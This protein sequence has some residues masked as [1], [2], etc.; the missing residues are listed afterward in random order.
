MVKDDVHRHRKPF[1]RMNP[2]LTILNDWKTQSSTVVMCLVLAAG[3]GN[4]GGDG[5][6]QGCLP[7][8]PAA[9]FAD[10]GLLFAT[11]SRDFQASSLHFMSFERGG[12]SC[13]ILSGESGDP[14]VVD[15]GRTEFFNRQIGRLNHKTIVRQQDKLLVGVEQATPSAGLGD[16]QDASYLD[17]SEL[18]LQGAN[19]SFLVDGV[20][21][22]VSKLDLGGSK[23]RPVKLIRYESKFL[24]LH[25]GL[26]ADFKPDNT[27]RL[28]VWQSGEFQDLDTSKDGT[29]G[30]PLTY[31]NPVAV[32]VKGSTLAVLSLCNAFIVC[33]E[34]VDE[35]DLTT[36]KLN[37][38]T[39]VAASDY[40]SV[41]SAVIFDEGFYSIS[42]KGDSNYLVKYLF[43]DGATTELLRLT[44]PTAPALFYDEAA[45]NLYAG[46]LES[47]SAGA[48]HHFADGQFAGTIRVPGRPYSGIIWSA[49]SP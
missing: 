15:S 41:G 5:A 19:G 12:V 37:K 16:P 1:L 48:L 36:L 32:R 23:F 46:D 33:T 47:T 39:V 10:R 4:S 31:S 38:Q 7:A 35:V 44:D 9:Y 34:G 3:C 42:T 14:L 20:A 45:K 43:A 40:K 30:I 6:Q 22:D 11:T 18:L 28:F 27:Q 13:N 8:T 17:G 49:L 29:Q 25:V 2:Q 21:K 26:G 24:L